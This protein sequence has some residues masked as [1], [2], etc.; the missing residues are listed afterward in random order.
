[1][2]KSRMIDYQIKIMFHRLQNQSTCLQEMDIA[3]IESQHFSNSFTEP[4]L[5][6]YFTYWVQSLYVMKMRL[7]YC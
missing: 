2:L 7:S 5:D 1:M 6:Y 4:L 3:E